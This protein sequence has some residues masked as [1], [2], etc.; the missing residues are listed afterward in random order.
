[1]GNS[2]RGGEGSRPPHNHWSLCAFWSPHKVSRELDTSNTCFTDRN[3][4]GIAV[5]STR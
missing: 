2:I 4:L 3:G 5:F 1:M